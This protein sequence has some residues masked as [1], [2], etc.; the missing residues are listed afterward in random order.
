MD[1]ANE[2]RS[3]ELMFFLQGVKE[4]IEDK[5]PD[6]CGK[7]RYHRQ[8]TRLEY[9]NVHQPRKRQRDD[10]V[11]RHFKND[12]VENPFFEAFIE[13]DF[14]KSTAAVVKARSISNVF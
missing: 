5:I 10:N 12:S 11:G 8:R 13:F 9:R 14:H 2:K 4:L 7:C 6:R 1:G 3:L